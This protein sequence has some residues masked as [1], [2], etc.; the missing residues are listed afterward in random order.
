MTAEMRAIVYR[1]PGDIRLD[2]IPVSGCRDDEIRIRVDACAV[3]GTDL[4]SRLHGN[5]KITPPMVIGHELTGTVDTVGAKVEGFAIGDRIAMAT[6]ISCGEC[7]Y[8]KRGWTNLCIDLAAMGFRY[9]GGMAEYTTIPARALRNGHVVKVPA[10]VDPVH[11]ALAE[12]VSC[13]VNALENCALAAGDTIVVIGAGPMGILNA[14]VARILNARKVI[15]ADT[16]PARLAR[17]AGF[18]FDRLIDPASEDLA[19]AVKDETDGL[20]ADVVVV[21]APAARPQ[22][23]ALGMVRKRGTVCL[24]ASLPA[25]ESIITLAAGRSTTTSFGSSGRA[26]PRPRMC[27]ARSNSSRAIRSRPAR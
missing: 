22:E 3:C 15:L 13:C 27:A 23:Q 21:A 16:N 6:S 24:F 14:C 18:G 2:G 20:G 5:P 4:K 8:C 10:G 9:P 1:G 11:A 7:A 17:A 26:I 25:G 12:P 19:R